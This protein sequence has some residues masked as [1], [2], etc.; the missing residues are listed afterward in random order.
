MRKVFILLVVLSASVLLSG[1]ALISKHTAPVEG[2][3][4]T[5]FGLLSL[6]KIDNGYPML[7]V[8]SGFKKD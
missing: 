1:C 6:D 3:T 5:T 8:Y 2:G 4:K 7:P